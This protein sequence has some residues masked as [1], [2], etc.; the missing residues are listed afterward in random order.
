MVL[1]PAK[2][3]INE[4]IDVKNGGISIVI[5]YIYLNKSFNILFFPR[6][7]F[8]FHVLGKTDF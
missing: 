6:L 2:Q 7:I 4:L 5:F 3:S 1:S 8:F